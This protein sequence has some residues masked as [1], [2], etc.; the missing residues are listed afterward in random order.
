MDR[1]DIVLEQIN[2]NN[3]ILLDNCFF[4]YTDSTETYRN[5]SKTLYKAKRMKSLE[6]LTECIYSLDEAWRWE[7]SNIINKDNVYTIPEI[8]EEMKAFSTVLQNAYNW[9]YQKIKEKI[10]D[11]R[12]NSD[13]N[14]SETYP[15]MLYLNHLIK[16]ASE[17]DYGLVEAAMGYCMENSEDK[18]AIFSGD[19]HIPLIIR[20]F[21]LEGN[22]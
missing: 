19:Q 21:L 3:F 22:N 4:G 15:V 14:I 10:S 5:L 12:L 6:K 17:T 16:D 7:L 2:E 8:I 20:S 11:K 1:K 9:H 13:T 18:I